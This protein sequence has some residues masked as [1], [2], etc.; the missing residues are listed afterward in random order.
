MNGETE[1]SLCGLWIQVRKTPRDNKFR[2]GL[3]ILDFWPFSHFVVFL[4]I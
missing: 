2:Q 3:V 1:A 4:R